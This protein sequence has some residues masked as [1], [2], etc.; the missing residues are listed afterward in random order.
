M[1]SDLPSGTGS[2]WLTLAEAVPLGY[3]L[4]DSVAQDLGVRALAIKGPVLTQQGLRDVKESVD[5]DVLVD[6]RGFTALLARMLELGW[7]DTEPYNLPTVMPR[8]SATLRHPIWPCEFDLH[9]YFPGFL[10]DPQEVFDVLWEYR[11]SAL[12]AGRSLPCPAPEGHVMIAALHYLRDAKQARAHERL[13][14]LAS[15]VRTWPQDRLDLAV[16]LSVATGAD[17][18]LAQ[19]MRTLGVPTSATLDHPG[20]AEWRLR[21][22]SITTASLAWWVD[23]RR[24]T[25]REKPARVKRALWPNTDEMNRIL[26]SATPEGPELRKARRARLKRGLAQ[27]PQAIREFRRAVR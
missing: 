19:F 11:D 1:A 17:S 15:V 16:K 8:H 14:E 4:L 12:I 24:A 21:S 3:A 20:L 6:P 2:T 25:W 23:I 26:R 18:T 5:V 27:V 7:V 13:T 10:A 22:E 9:H